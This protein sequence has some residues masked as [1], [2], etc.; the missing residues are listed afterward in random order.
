MKWDLGLNFYSENL[1]IFEPGQLEL[2]EFRNNM[3]KENFHIY[4]VCKRKKLFLESCVQMDDKCEIVV[5]QLNE[6]HEKVFLKY[7]NQ[8]TISI[9]SK[10]DGIY[11]ITVNGSEKDWMYDYNLISI[12][13]YSNDLTIN[14]DSRLP[15]DLEVLYVGQAFGR[16]KPR[17]IDYR[18][19]NHEKVQ[20]I[21][22]DILKKG[23]NE[24]VLVIGVT[25]NS[26]DLKSSF[27]SQKSQTKP[28][29]IEELKQTLTKSQRRLTK[30][31]QVT[32]FEASLINYFKPSLNTEY[33]Q[34]FPSKDFTSYNELYGID[35]DYSAMEIDTKEMG[36]RLYSQEVPK[37]KFSHTRHFP[38]RSKSDKKTLFE[39]L[40]ELRED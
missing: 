26:R 40:Y 32:V 31:Q 16:T 34:T 36:I 33:K 1:I 5:Y 20:K 4:L 27:V 10:S 2:A 3:S 37:R 6:K 23:S 14:E 19:S 22:L 28:P 18:L 25:V 39:Y 29:T 8:N 11:Q 35:F 24:E 9:D 17:T 12:L 21:A 15:S 7:K 30:A 38:L 13:D